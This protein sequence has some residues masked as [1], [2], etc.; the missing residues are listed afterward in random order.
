MVSPAVLVLTHDA[1]DFLPW[2]QELVGAGVDFAFDN[3]G[4]KESIETAFACLKKRGQCAIA[5]GFGVEI[6]LNAMEILLGKKIGGVTEGE[7]VPRIFIPQMIELYRQG[8]FPFDRLITPYEFK[9]INEA[10]EDS[11][12][13]KV[14][15]PVLKF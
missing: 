15:K 10:I 14:V 6:K 8:R 7:S 3:T 11:K 4:N 5:A 13:G 2:L 9:D 1:E 12:S